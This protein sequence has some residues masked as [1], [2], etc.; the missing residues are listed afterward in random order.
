MRFFPFF[1][2]FFQLHNIFTRLCA[3]Q[4]ARVPIINLFRIISIKGDLLRLCA[5][6]FC[7]L[8]LFGFVKRLK[9]ENGSRC[10]PLPLKMVVQINNYIISPFQ[11]CFF[12]PMQVGPYIIFKCIY[13]FLCVVLYTTI[14]FWSLKLYSFASRDKRP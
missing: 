2:F 5:A 3:L 13:Y 1:F 7:I 9:N 8:C 12:F 4:C 14:K 11:H 6:I 10:P